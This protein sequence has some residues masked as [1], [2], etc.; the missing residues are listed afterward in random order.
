MKGN[1]QSMMWKMGGTRWLSLQKSQLYMMWGT[2]PETQWHP[3]Y[4]SPETDLHSS[5]PTTINKE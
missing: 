2:S 3:D 4:G 5:S 1:M